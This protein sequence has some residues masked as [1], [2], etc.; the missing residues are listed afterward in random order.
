MI[1][2]KIEVR[3]M[4]DLKD[5]RK[6]INEELT[7]IEENTSKNT[8]KSSNDSTAETVSLKNIKNRHW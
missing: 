2:I 6:Q 1:I 8:Q 4:E 3:K 7:N 5:I